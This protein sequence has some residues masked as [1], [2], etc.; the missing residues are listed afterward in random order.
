MSGIPVLIGFPVNDVK[1]QYDYTLLSLHTLFHYET[2]RSKNPETI[3][4]VSIS[5]LEHRTVVI[6]LSNITIHPSY[7][8]I[9]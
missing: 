5:K 3:I 9:R 7:Y 1:L 6:S 4:I 2:L 8:R